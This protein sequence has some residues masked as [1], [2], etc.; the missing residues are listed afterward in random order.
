M[1]IQLEQIDLLQP[2]PQ[3]ALKD[4][5]HAVR[6]LAFVGTAP[7]G[8]VICR[9]ARRGTISHRSLRKR[10]A[11]RHALTLLRMLARQG[12]SAGPEA[13]R[14]FPTEAKSPFLLTWSK[15]RQSMVWV[16]RNLMLPAGL[17]APYRDWVIQSQS[18]VNYLLPPVTVVVCTRDRP[19]ALARCIESLKQLDYPSLEIMIVDNSAE[20]RA[21][22]DVVEQAGVTY[23]RV[24]AKGLSRARNA[25]LQLAATRWVAFTDDDCRPEKNWLKELVR[26]LQDTNCA[27]VTG[28]V[29]PAALENA[30]E[31]TFEIY[32]GL[33]RGYQDKA[34]DGWSIRKSRLHPVQTWRF[35]AGAN[36]LIDAPRVLELGGFD[37]DLG[38][39]SA[40]PCSEDTEIWYHLLKCWHSIHYT[41]RAI[42]HHHHRSSPEELR[43]QIY[44]YAKGHAAYHWRCLW[45]YRDHRSLL[46]LLLFLPL[47]FRKNLKMG[48]AAKTKYPFSLVFLEVKGTFFGP[49][50]YTRAKARRWMHAVADRL[51]HG[52]RL[53][54]PVP[55]DPLPEPAANAYDA[56]DR[57]KSVRVA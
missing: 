31:I 38:A 40:A 50:L 28:L 2:W 43:K 53:M 52:R 11:R 5:Y 51:R 54:G 36:M 15:W 55:A 8:E 57:N 4:G 22:R 42:V 17:P 24:P 30:A 6:V 47:W 32:G 16:E 7:L 27:C 41:P 25:A 9:P 1:R 35:G 56:V 18:H 33:G 39:G 48:M 3:I 19:E 46:H 12:L 14:S 34:W 23:T 21:T 20:P 13:L 37:L 29:L 26:P 10:L 45:V 49:L 44:A